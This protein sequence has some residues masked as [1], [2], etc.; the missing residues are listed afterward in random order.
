MLLNRTEFWMMNNPVRAA[1]QRFFEAKRLLAMGGAVRGGRALEVGC[2]RGVGI[3]MIIDTFRAGRVDG[4]DLD[5][6]MVRKAQRR[7]EHRGDRVSLWLG[8]ATAIPIENGR[9]DAVFDFGIV[10]HIPDWRAAIREI[11]R[12]L[13]PGGRFYAE[14]VL[15]RVITHPLSRRLVH[16]PQQ[17]RFDD[18][19]F[20]DALSEAGFVIVNVRRWRRYFAWFI[21][22]RADGKDS[23]TTSVAGP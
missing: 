11:H 22:D 5:P 4:F 19:Q 23:R 10:H 21:A 20:Q 18:E 3:E 12:V 17:D 15:S 6:R 1:V 2:G 7:H 13:R 14:E 8:N 9:Y 16:H